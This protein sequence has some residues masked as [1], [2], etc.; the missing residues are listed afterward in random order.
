MEHFY[1]NIH[2]WFN[3]PN[4]YKRMVDRMVDGSHCVE[5]GTWM[6]ASA[7]FMAVEIIN[8]GKNVKFDCV[9]TWKGSVEH[10]NVQEVINDTL[11]EKFLSNIEPVKHIIN[12]IRMNSVTAAGLYNNESLDFV[13]IDACHD[14]EAVKKDVEAWYP[15][16][17]RG[18]IISG[19]DYNTWDGVTRAV[20][21]Y[22]KVHN[23][24]LETPDE[25]DCWSIAK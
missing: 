24:S 5:V 1:K 25:P 4:F 19:H 9:D 14:Y 7:A 18:G 23:Y 10:C 6:G 16:V 2:G 12:P 8:S 21:E 22:A 13:F 11:F 17:K 20:N 15:K 3:Y